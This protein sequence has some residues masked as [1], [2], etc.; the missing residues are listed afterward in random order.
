MQATRSHCGQKLLEFRTRLG[1]K[2]GKIVEVVRECKALA[3]EADEQVADDID[4]MEEAM[5]SYLFETIT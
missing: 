1:E 3:C 5:L 2:I 4:P